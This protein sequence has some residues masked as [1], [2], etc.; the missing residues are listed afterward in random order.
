MS[1]NVIVSFVVICSFWFVTLSQGL[2]FV[3]AIQRASSGTNDKMTRDF[4]YRRVTE[5]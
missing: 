3:T 5:T 1:F 4:A 2:S